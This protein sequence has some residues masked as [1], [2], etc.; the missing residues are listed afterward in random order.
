MG[1]FLVL[2]ILMVFSFSVMNYVIR[3]KEGEQLYNPDDKFDI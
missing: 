1:T 3:D 2:L